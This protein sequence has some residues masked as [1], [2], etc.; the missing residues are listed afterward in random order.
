MKTKYVGFRIEDDIYKKIIK[1]K[2]D[3]TIT[4]FFCE[5]IQDTFEAQKKGTEDYGATMQRIE[6]VMQRLENTLNDSTKEHELTN[7]MEKILSLLEM[8]L[9]ISVAIAA[10][11][12]A[13][14][15]TIRRKY[16]T[17]I[18]DTIGKR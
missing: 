2:Q 5:I 9:Q 17:L 8:T 1:L 6:M 10:S 14:T 3:K 16:P 15:N 12:P 18:E 11:S 13:S 7:K 4:H